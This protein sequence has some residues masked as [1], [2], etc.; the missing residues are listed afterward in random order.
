MDFILGA[1]AASERIF[2]ERSN[3]LKLFFPSTL[4]LLPYPLH[5]YF[6]SI[7]PP[8]CPL[9][10]GASPCPLLGRGGGGLPHPF[11]EAA[12]LRFVQPALFILC[13]GNELFYCLLYLFNF[14]EGPLGR[15]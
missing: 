12:S 2:K 3:L 4:T 1:V 13:A 8:C 7:V 5:P 9:S 14:S 15:R 11:A 10:E 6:P